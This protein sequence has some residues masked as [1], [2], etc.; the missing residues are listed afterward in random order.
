MSRSKE[1][2]GDDLCDFCPIERHKRVVSGN[3]GGCSAG[4]EGSRCSD[5]YEI[6]LEKHE[7]I[8]GDIS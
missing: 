3:N 6:Y 1:E 8:Y 4:C 7:E 5:A 2:L